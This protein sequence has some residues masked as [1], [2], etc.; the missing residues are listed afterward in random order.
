[1]HPNANKDTTHYNRL[2]LQET[3]MQLIRDWDIQ[4]SV[5]HLIIDHIIVSVDYQYIE[6]RNKDY[7]CFSN[8]TTKT[9]IA[10]ISQAWCRVS[11]HHKK[12][13]RGA[14]MEP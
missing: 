4:E 2:V 14:F 6:A 3:Q 11:T 5:G 7:T 9:N 1:M 12:S 13:A 10:Y 8:E